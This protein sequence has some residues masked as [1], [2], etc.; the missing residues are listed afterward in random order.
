[1]SFIKVPSPELDQVKLDAVVLAF[2][3]SKVSFSQ[4]RPSSPADTEIFSSKI[5][6]MVSLIVGQF[7][8]LVTDIDRLTPLI[9]SW[10]EGL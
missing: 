7:N 3:I 8:P 4:I 10:L 1:M 5:T 2:V 6:L 9:K